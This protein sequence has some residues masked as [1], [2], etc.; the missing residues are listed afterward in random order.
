MSASESTGT[1]S[2]TESL[3][4]TAE[5]WPAYLT[6]L[7]PWVYQYVAR[8]RAEQVPENNPESTE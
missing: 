2:L 5:T 3:L 4:R 6:P 8:E 7:P 1:G